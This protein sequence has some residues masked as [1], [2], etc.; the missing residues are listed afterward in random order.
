MPRIPDGTRQPRPKKAAGTAVDPRNGQK[1]VNVSHLPRHE[2]FDPPETV[3]SE[4]ALDA[5]EGF[6]SDRQP[7]LITPSARHIVIRWIEAVER[8]QKCTSEADLDPV[9][10][11]STG[12]PVLNPLYKV[13]NEALQT[14]MK[15]EKILGIGPLNATALGLAVIQEQQGLS[16]INS[17]VTDVDDDEEDDEDD[18]RMS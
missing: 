16:E 18:P 12:Q 8:Y 6:W 9:Q 13:A 1:L 11:G 14:V 17:R 2:Y 3:K 15:C 7:H 10:E 4:V 5:W